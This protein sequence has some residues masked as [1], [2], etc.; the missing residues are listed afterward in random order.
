MQRIISLLLE[1]WFDLRFWEKYLNPQAIKPVECG[2]K[3]LLLALL[4]LLKDDPL[5]NRVLGLV[6]ADFERLL[7][8]PLPPLNLVYTDKNDL[9][10]SLLSLQIKAHN[11]TTM[12]TL[13]DRLADSTKKLAFE[14]DQE[15]RLDQY[16]LSVARQFGVLRY[17][18]CRERWSVDFDKLKVQN[19]QW[20]CH[21]TIMLDTQLLHTKM[22]EQI[23]S[24]NTVDL[25]T[26]QAFI[27]EC[28]KQYSDYWELV[29]GHDVMQLLVLVLNA[30]RLR[31]EYGHSHI[32]ENHLQNYLRLMVRFEDIKASPM[33][34]VIQS[35]APRGVQFFKIE[36]GK[37]EV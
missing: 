9:E 34:S 8:N 3:S 29:R 31:P 14:K 25:P 33:V 21:S 18:S 28:I 35:K 5:E 17:L 1:G 12:E 16:I 20:L 4:D 23:P 2:G 6:D 27:Q 10:T 37:A 22:L 7:K 24:N 15:S 30:E 13:M 11:Q 36:G 26:L 32:T 19:Q